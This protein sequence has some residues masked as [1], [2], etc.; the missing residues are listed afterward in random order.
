[1]SLLN[2]CFLPWLTRQAAV[3]TGTFSWAS[4]ARCRLRP[5]VGTVAGPARH[6]PAWGARPRASWRGAGGVPHQGSE[7]WGAGGVPR[8]GSAN[9]PGLL[10]DS[11]REAIFSAAHRPLLRTRK[12][13]FRIRFRVQ[14]PSASRT[15]QPVLRA[16]HNASPKGRV[17]Q[18]SR[19]P[20]PQS[21]RRARRTPSGEH[22]EAS[23]RGSQAA[24]ELD[25]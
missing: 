3:G 20:Q 25:T 16:F 4:A 19:S 9:N 18:A 14:L 11:Q 5:S 13:V 8:R 1:M 21:P 17:R 6:T 12:G 15:R 23:G 10:S 24:W 2:G 7:N 22:A